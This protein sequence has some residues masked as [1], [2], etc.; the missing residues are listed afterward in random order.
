MQ[1]GV[2]TAKGLSRRGYQRLLFGYPIQPV[3]KASASAD[4]TS[5]S[6]CRAIRTRWI[7]IVDRFSPP[8]APFDRPAT[9]YKLPHR[10]TVN[11]SA[12]RLGM[13][14]NQ[15]DAPHSQLLF[16]AHLAFDNSSVR[17]VCE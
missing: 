3:A 17:L 9:L 1:A 16:Q 12:F 6:E 2:V 13:V 4:H 11:R 15:Q 5:T 14:I 7:K 10:G 8:G